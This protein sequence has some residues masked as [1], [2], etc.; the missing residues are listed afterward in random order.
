MRW[1]DLEGASKYWG[2][3]CATLSSYVGVED[4]NL[5]PFADTKGTLATELSP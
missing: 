4:L 2:Y 3:K 5:D 1:K